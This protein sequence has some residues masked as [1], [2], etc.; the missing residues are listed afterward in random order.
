MDPFSPGEDMVVWFGT[1]VK[2]RKVGEIR[3]DPRVTLYYPDPDDGGYVTITGTAIIV[4]DPQETKIRW[5]EEWESFYP[6]REKDYVLIKVTPILLDVLSY[7]H[8]I[9]GNPETWR[10]ASVEF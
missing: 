2:S 9:T 5:K 1:N 6:D 4:D 3:K 7:K 10:I 8:K